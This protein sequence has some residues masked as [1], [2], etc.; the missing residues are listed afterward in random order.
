MVCS[1]SREGK[2]TDRNGTL[3]E[4]TVV[5]LITIDDE[6]ATL[7]VLDTTVSDRGGTFS[8][9]LDT[10]SNASVLLRA[11]LPNGALDGFYAGATAFIPIHPLTQALVE[12]VV[13][14]TETPGGR[15]LTD[16]TAS[17]IRELEDDL[18]GL[19]ASELEFTDEDAVKEFVRLEVGRRIAEAAGG[20]I[21]TQTTE[22]LE[23]TTTSTTQGFGADPAGLCSVPSLIVLSGEQFR[24][25]VERDGTLCGESNVLLPPILSEGAFQLL[26]TAENFQPQDVPEFPAHVGDATVEDGR[27]LVLGPGTIGSAVTVTRKVYIPE[28]GDWVRYLDIFENSSGS[29]VTVSLDLL[30][31]LTTSSDS[32]LLTFDTDGTAPTTEDRFVAAYDI[33]ELRPTVGFAFQDG[34]GS[35]TLS[36]L[37][38]PGSAGGQPGDVRFQW[39]NLS[40]PPT[41]RVA[42]LHYGCLTTSRSSSTVSETLSALVDDPNMDGMSLTELAA[43]VNFAPTKGT[44]IGDA[45]SVIGRA[46]LTGVEVDGNGDVT[47]TSYSTLADPDGSFALPIDLQE[48]DRVRLTTDAGLNQ[49]L[50]VGDSS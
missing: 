43:L 50:T 22:E 33:F 6:G 13:D 5:E 12:L 45:G 15:T 4:G 18:F 8:F 49:V 7:S 48:G 25:D 19:D 37:V 27:E 47:G 3:V 20:Q 35:I 42:L 40:V 16:F 30:S 31:R 29:A 26:S 11:Y 28:T 14:I 41:G 32:E 44:V 17:E 21:T 9:P 34:L 36:D 46:E 38:A 10:N 23:G 39:N 1:G 2:L 24:F